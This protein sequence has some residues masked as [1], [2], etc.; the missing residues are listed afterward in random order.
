MR[1]LE[2][3]SKI[4]ERNM[5]HQDGVEW[6][7][8]RVLYHASHTGNLDSI[9]DFGVIPMHGEIV[10]GTESHQTYE[11]WGEELQELSFFSPDDIGFVN[12]QVGNKISKNMH[13]VTVDDI[14]EHGLLTILYPWKHASEIWCSNADGT[15]TSLEGDTTYDVPSHVEGP[16]CFSFDVVAPDVILTGDKLINYLEK[17]QPDILAWAQGKGP[18]ADPSEYEPVPHP[19]AQ[20]QMRLFAEQFTSDQTALKRY[21]SSDRMELDAYMHW[22]FMLEW[23]DEH[24]PEVAAKIDRDEPSE[25][26]E[27]PDKIRMELEQDIGE[28]LQR[29][30][31]MHDPANLDTKAH[32]DFNR[33]VKTPEWYVHFSDDANSI[34][35]KGFTKGVDDITKL[36]LTTHLG[37]FDKK[38]GGFNFAFMADSRDAKK[39]ASDRHMYGEDIVMFNMRGAIEVSHY[40]DEE[41]QYIVYGK[42]LDPRNLILLTYNDGYY[43][44]M[45]HPSKWRK[46]PRDRVTENMDYNEAIVWVAKN[47]DQYRKI[48]TGW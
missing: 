46:Y 20:K 47:V 11:E 39:V 28:D 1:L 40:G 42:E 33:M 21:L 25:W 48:I 10:Q 43:D 34:A 6:Q 26:Y 38:Y 36:G 37:D 17:V 5:Q 14:R 16:D 29:D 24:Y 45:V 18:S 30:Q 31:M 2:F 32:M 4:N 35:S 27:L 13:D 41:T 7:N 19:D 3:F 15:A 8:V 9:R 22:D 12:W 23:L 44:V